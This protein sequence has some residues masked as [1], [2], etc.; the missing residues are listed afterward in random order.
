M[1]AMEDLDRSFDFADCR[2]MVQKKNITHVSDT[3]LSSASSEMCRMVLHVEEGIALF[4]F[5]S[6]T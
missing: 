3:Q 2:P 5:S 1:R 6:A 4:V